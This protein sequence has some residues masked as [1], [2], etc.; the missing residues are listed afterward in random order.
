M[1][2][3]FVEIEMEDP[4]SFFIAPQEQILTCD[5]AFEGYAPKCVI[6]T[7]ILGVLL[8]IGICV[9]FGIEHLS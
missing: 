3:P 8:L 5:K 1:N 9:W 4:E 7:L 6:V 2:E